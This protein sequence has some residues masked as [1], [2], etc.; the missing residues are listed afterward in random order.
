MN[1]MEQWVQES[2]KFS[3]EFGPQLFS[4]LLVLAVGVIAAA[5]IHRW[6][7]KLAAKSEKRRR[8]ITIAGN[9][10][11]FLLAAFV[12]ILAAHNAGFPYPVVARVLLLA[13]LIVGA[14]YLIFRPFIPTPPFKTGDTILAGGL[15]GKVEGV[16]FMHTRMRTFDGR[17][18]FV[19]NTALFKD[20]L[21]NYHSTPNR[22]IALDVTLQYGDDLARAKELMLEIMKSDER[23]HEKP[24][25][26]VYV[27]KLG[28]NGF[29]LGGRCWSA[30]VKYFR[31]R[32]DL[33]ERVLL[34]FT[35]E[36]G[37]HFAPPRREVLLRDPNADEAAAAQP[38]REEPPEEP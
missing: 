23:V 35:E 7:K 33:M 31:T 27:L 20:T 11:Y 24:A 8:A 9:A 28:E 13:V 6:M 25:P 15:F 36:P 22:R 12:L 2:M 3:R 21:I 19:P 30:N 5:L 17:T 10:I 26:K 32:C 14:L 18:I 38:G 16:T 29:L 37:L 1:A 4:N 34:A